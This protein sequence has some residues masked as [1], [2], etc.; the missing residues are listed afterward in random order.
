MEH[1]FICI[2]SICIFTLVRYLLRSLSL[3]FKGVIY[4]LIVELKTFLIVEIC[5]CVCVCVC[6]YEQGVVFYQKTMSFFYFEKFLTEVQYNS[7]ILVSGV[8][9]N[10]SIILYVAQCSSQ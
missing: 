10:G 6:V 8:Q 9:Y 5:V 4:F 7:V 1:L 2:F 3:F